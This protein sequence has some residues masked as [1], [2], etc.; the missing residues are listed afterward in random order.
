M[1]PS[2]RE[3]IGPLQPL[4]KRAVLSYGMRKPNA[5]VV[6]LWAGLMPMSR[7]S[8]AL[9][10]R[11]RAIRTESPDW[12]VLMSFTNMVKVVPG[13]GIEPATRGFSKLAAEISNC[14]Y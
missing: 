6:G 11:N 1:S 7:Y 4:A 10:C 9:Y 14:F 2:L 13:A 12:V 5:A 8:G 3:H